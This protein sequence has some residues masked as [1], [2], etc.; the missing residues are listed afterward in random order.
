M[1]PQDVENLELIKTYY[2]YSNDK[3]KSILSLLDNKQIEELK[4]R[5][6]QGGK[7]RK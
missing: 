6:N 5:I 7:S 2:G 4:Q 1:K 3:A